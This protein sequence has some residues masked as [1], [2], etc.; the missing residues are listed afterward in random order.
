MAVYMS[1][2]LNVCPDDPEAEASPIANLIRTRPEAFDFGDA[3]DS[4]PLNDQ[5]QVDMDAR[6]PLWLREMIRKHYDDAD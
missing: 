2:N 6:R 3:P 1:D 4:A 5:Y